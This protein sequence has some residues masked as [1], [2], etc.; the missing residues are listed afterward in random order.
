MSQFEV[1]ANKIGQGAERILERSS[2]EAHNYHHQVLS[3]SHITAA[4]IKLEWDVFSRVMRGL[5][6]DPYGI[7]SEVEKVLTGETPGSFV[8]ELAIHPVVN[9]VLRAALHNAKDSARLTIEVRDLFSAVF[10]E[11]ESVAVVIMK[12]HNVDL[13]SLKEAIKSAFEAKDTEDEHMKK[14]YELPAHLRH[15]AVNLN[16]LARQDHIP[17]VYFRDDEIRRVIEILCHRERP[18]SVMIIGEPGVGK[19]AVVDGL[20]RMIE[21][22][23]EQVPERLRECQIVTLEMNSVVAGTQ[24]RGMFEDRIQNVIR[25]IKENPN[26]ILFI[27]EAHTMIGAG[28]ALGAPSDAANILKS[29]LGRGEVRVIG[30][31]TLSEYKRYFE[32][33]EA[34]ARRFRVVH[35][36]EP[37]LEQTRHIVLQ[38]RPRLEDNYSVKIVD[39]AIEMAIEMAPRY[40]RHLRL[41]D[42]VIGWLDTASVRSEIEKRLKVTAADVVNVI[43]DAAKI[44]KDMVFRDVTERF[45]NIRRRLG[46]RV[47]GQVG[48]IEAVADCLILNK[49]PLKDGFD[50]PDGVLLFVGPTGVGKTEL[51]KAVAEFMFGDEK[52]MIRI[53]MAEY[54]GSSSV[55]KLIGM[56]RGIVGSDRGGILTNQLRDTPYS[57]VLLDEIEKASPELLNLFLAAF[58]EGWITDGR[59]KRVYLSDAIIIMTSNAG[60]RLFERMTNPLGFHSGQVSSDQLKKEINHELEH[61]FTPEFRNRIDEV[62]LFEPLAEEDVRNIA[63]KYIEQ[64]KKAMKKP[65]KEIV[66][67]PEALELIATKGYSRKYG[68]RFLKRFIDREIK[69]PISKIWK[70]SDTFV[71]TTEKERIIIKE[72]NK[73][74]A[75][76]GNGNGNHGAPV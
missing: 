4:L 68:A 73:N 18:N 35:V 45:K 5:N 61:T 57:V 47:I 11:E 41:P 29:V 42:K 8:Q 13:S 70:K 38:L 71:I 10:E 6:L 25:E 14:Q 72:Q 16:L 69:L 17:P 9:S 28:S 59:G 46:N 58:D 52:R 60:S 21:F 19:T 2:R 55:D 15:F 34:L 23:P 51:A 44:P 33:D 62:V 64:I 48:A 65:R 7:K 12:N 20:A 24:L 75:K 40:Q 3:T 67:E 66:V 50:R 22:E 54:Q 76:N 74:G 30:A 49:G 43:A 27:D 31:T 32:E 53:D 63:L 39:E 1:A 26:L 56:P 37:A 36:S